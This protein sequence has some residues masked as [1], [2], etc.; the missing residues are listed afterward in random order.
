MTETARVPAGWYNDPLGTSQLRWWD[1]T[2]WTE[3]TTPIDAGPP[4]SEASVAD[5]EN[6]LIAPLTAHENDVLVIHP[7]PRNREVHH[8]SSSSTAAPN[9]TRPIDF[10]PAAN[11]APVT[12]IR[13]VVDISPKTE[14][15]SQPDG[16]PV[17][18]DSPFVDL[19]SAVDPAPAVKI[20]EAR[21]P[22]ISDVTLTAN[23]WNALNRAIAG[24]VHS[25]SEPLVELR[26]SDAPTL[27][28]DPHNGIYWWAD[29]LNSFSAGS[30]DGDVETI[31]RPAGLHTYEAGHDWEPLVWLIGTRADPESFDSLSLSGA[32][33]KLRRW[34][35]LTTLNHTTEQMS[36]TAMLGAAHLTIIELATLAKVDAD[37]ARRLVSTFEIMGLLTHTMDT[38]SGLVRDSVTAA[39]SK[40]GIFSRL[41]ARFSR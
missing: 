37:D 35:N 32:R 10:E 20:P 36:M 27:V 39:A 28:I 8:G 21:N 17:A 12:D 11:I 14:S 23:T 18:D 34:P 6:E 33:F 25:A 16:S 15:V 1:A 38:T 41:K 31:P 5:S 19:G 22:G 24:A 3:H 40:E 13:P 30:T 4:A 7:V 29:P 9:P 26:F 2:A